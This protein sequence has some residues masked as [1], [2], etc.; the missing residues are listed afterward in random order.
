[1]KSDEERAQ[2]IVFIVYHSLL[3]A[4][5][6]SRSRIKVKSFPGEENIPEVKL[7]QEGVFVWLPGKYY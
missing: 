7:K 4:N 3:V 6:L 1:V 2:S 5:H